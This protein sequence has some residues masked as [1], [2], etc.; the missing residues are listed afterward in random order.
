M[1]LRN[2]IGLAVKDV[3]D[4]ILRLRAAQKI[5]DD[6][7]ADMWHNVLHDMISHLVKEACPCIPE[8]LL[9]NCPKNLGEF[10]VRHLGHPK[11]EPHR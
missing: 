4:V 7:E 3:N 11:G 2:S 10:C 9:P 5:G 1:T 8:D 6:K